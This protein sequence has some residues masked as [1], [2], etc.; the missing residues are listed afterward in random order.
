[1]R[2]RRCMHER[3]GAVGEQHQ[4]NITEQ[5]GGKSGRRVR[6][7]RRLRAVP[8]VAPVRV[9]PVATAPARTVAGRNL[10]QPERRGR[11]RH[12]FGWT[13]APRRRWR[14]GRRRVQQEHAAADDQRS[15]TSRHVVQ[16]IDAQ[17][18]IG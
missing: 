17:T 9:V 5:G 6:P 10:R 2:V 8:G 15:P 3:Y 1:M 14:D 12:L 7:R 11:G 13:P 4:P 16:R 18:W